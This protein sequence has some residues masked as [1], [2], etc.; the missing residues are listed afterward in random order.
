[1]TIKQVLCHREAKR[2]AGCGCLPAPARIMRCAETESDVD[3]GVSVRIDR[4]A[5]RIAALDADVGSEALGAFDHDSFLA[6]SIPMRCFGAARTET[7]K[8][9]A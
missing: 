2:S 9:D 7:T 3:T 1:M 6:R 8:I 5:D 4:E